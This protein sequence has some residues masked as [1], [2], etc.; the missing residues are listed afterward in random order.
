MDSRIKKS[1]T[2]QFRIIFP[3]NLNDQGTLF[4]GTAMQWMDEVAYITATRFAKKKMVTVS[5]EKVQFLLP[6]KSGTIA[7]IVGKVSKVKNVTIEIHVEIYLEEMYSDLKQKV[8]EASFTFA[9]TN[10]FN[11]PIPII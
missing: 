10:N 3:K 2:R 11:K 6:I 5:S 9:A 1:E 8:V 7:E 4:G